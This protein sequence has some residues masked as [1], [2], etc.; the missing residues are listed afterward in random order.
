M[1]VK[2]LGP[3]DSVMVSP[4]GLHRKNQ[5]KAYPANVAEDLVKNS[6]RQHFKPAAVKKAPK[7]GGARKKK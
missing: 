7:K 2:Y 3:R 5:V 4:Y 1:D 6:R